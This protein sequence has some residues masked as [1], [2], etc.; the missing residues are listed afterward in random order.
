[1]QTPT[2]LCLLASA[3]LTACSHVYWTDCWTRS[4]GAMARTVKDT[5]L[6]KREARRRLSP[7]GKPYYRLLEEGLHLG[8]RKSNGRKGRPATGGKWVTRI[9]LGA[10][11]YRVEN[12]DGV[13]DDFTDAD[14]VAVLNFKQ[15]QDKA[16]ERFQR[17]AH[18]E[19][20]MSGPLTVAD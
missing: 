5:S 9:Y 16:R 3:C 12:I 7:R 18:D 6:D 2:L 20:G 4:G 1:Q 11:S 14:G 15:A 13:A 17:S 19:A 10:Q 8:Y